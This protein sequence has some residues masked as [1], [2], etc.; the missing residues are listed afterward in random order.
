[1]L[2]SGQP[3]QRSS[4]AMVSGLKALNEQVEQTAEAADV[5]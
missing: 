4:R 3:L 5:F 1:M 2:E